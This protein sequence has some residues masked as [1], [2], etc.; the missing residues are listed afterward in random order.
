MKI[1]SLEAEIDK[2]RARVS[3]LESDADVAEQNS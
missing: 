3:K 2:L 1:K